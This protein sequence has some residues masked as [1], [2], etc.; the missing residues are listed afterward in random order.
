MLLLQSYTDESKVSMRC[1]TLRGWMK[2]ES[3]SDS[4]WGV[5]LRGFALPP[6][7]R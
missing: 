4:G 1:I 3:R 2:R 5:V 7:P 6:Q